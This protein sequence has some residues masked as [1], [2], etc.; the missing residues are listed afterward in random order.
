MATGSRPVAPCTAGEMPCG[1]RI[2]AADS[3][4]RDV[5]AEEPSDEILGEGWRWGG[6]ERRAPQGAKPSRSSDRTRSISASIA[7]R[8]ND[9]LG[10]AVRQPCVLT[11][12]S[13]SARHPS[14]R[15]SRRALHP[16]SQTRVSSRVFCAPPLSKSHVPSGAASRLPPLRTRWS[17]PVCAG[18]AQAPEPALS[19][20][21]RTCLMIAS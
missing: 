1:L 8:S 17:P 11:Y 18:A 2:Q 12:L 19:P 7:S 15:C 13:A 10:M 4:L 21:G 16:A 5:P 14:L 9:G 6:A 3:L 20:P